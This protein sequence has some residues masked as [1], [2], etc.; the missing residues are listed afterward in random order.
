MEQRIS[1]LTIGADDL[2]AMKIFYEQVV[3]WKAIAGN[4]DIAFYKLNGFLLSIC[5]RKALADFIGVDHHGSGFRSITFG[6]N[7]ETREEVLNLYNELKD[8]VK[9]LKAPAE[10]PFGGLF[11]YFAD[12]EG[13]IIEIAQNPYIT[14][15]TFN[16]AI[17]HKAIDNL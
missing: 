6:Y 7:V 11:F 4:K 2:D 12:I 14:L 1:V 3:G 13:N 10:P 15:D 9:I 8:K 17:D 5:N 16:N